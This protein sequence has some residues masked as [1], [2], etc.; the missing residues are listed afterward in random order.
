MGYYY[1]HTMT[2]TTP[3]VGHATS[4]RDV[5][6]ADR[7][8]SSRHVLRPVGP[9]RTHPC[10]ARSLPAP[11]PL[12]APLPLTASAH[13]GGVLLP[14][15]RRPLCPCRPPHRPPAASRPSPRSSRPS[16][17]SP[18]AAPPPRRPP[19]RRRRSRCATRARRRRSPSPSSPT[20]SATSSD[21]KLEW[22]G[23]T[24]SGPQDIQ[25]AATGQ[26]DFG[27]AFNGAIVKLVA[28]GAP[29]KAVIGYYG[30]DDDAFNGY[31]VLEDSPIKLGPRPRSA[32]RSA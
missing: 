20:T 19:T 17:R 16:P 1:G 4:P 26:T 22:V 13:A 28:A 31:Y 11:R 27:G 21:V 23:N 2:S 24:I 32:R 3:L 5:A 7:V 6:L 14:T 29:I 12:I 18:P 15:H 30:A 10:P 8:L 25:S 9:R